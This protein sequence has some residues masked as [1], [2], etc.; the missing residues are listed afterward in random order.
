MTAHRTAIVTGGLQG[1]G[2]AIALE[3]ADN[4]LR[5]ATGSRRARAAL[6]A[7]CAA[8]TRARQAQYRANAADR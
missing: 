6:G 5:V 7:K 3:L 2:L 1:I 4:G 8:P